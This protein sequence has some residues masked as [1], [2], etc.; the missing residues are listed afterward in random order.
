[1]MTINRVKL[2][3]KISNKVKEME[4][5]Y[6]IDLKSWRDDAKEELEGELERAVAELAR[7]KREMEK[8]K[9]PNWEPESEYRRPKE[10]NRLE[11]LRDVI[12]VLQMSDDEVIK[13]TPKLEKAL[14]WDFK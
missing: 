1:M 6:K 7:V 14:G 5:E 4:E 9:K 3:T 12:A 2:L 8:S 10:P 13:M 11:Q